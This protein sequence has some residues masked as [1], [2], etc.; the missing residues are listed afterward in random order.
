MGKIFEHSKNCWRGRFVR[1]EGPR[2]YCEHLRTYHAD[3]RTLHA[4][5]FFGIFNARTV[6]E[7]ELNASVTGPLSQF[8][9]D[10]QIEI[11][12]KDNNCDNEDAMP[13]GIY[14]LIDKKTN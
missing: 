9:T 3:C 10:T 14:V 5:A 4:F 13:I 6:R 7:A 12:M 8:Y 11:T 1:R 2:T